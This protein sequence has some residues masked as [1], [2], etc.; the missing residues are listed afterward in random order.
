MAPPKA[1]PSSATESEQEL[2][3]TLLEEAT[4]GLFITG[5][6]MRL[7]AVNPRGC[8][9]TGYS[10]D[11]LRQRTIV[12]LLDPTELARAPLQILESK[13][14]ETLQRERL[15]VRRDGTRVPYEITA[16]RLADGRILGVVRDISE[17]RR[18]MDRLLVGTQAIDSALAGIAFSDLQARITYANASFL[19][20]WGFEHVEEVAG[21][22]AIEFWTT[23]EEPTAVIATILAQGS[24]TGEMTAKR[25]DG[26]TFEAELA[27]TLLRDGDGKAVGLMASFQ[28]ISK[29]KHDERHI[30][31][32]ARLYALLSGVNQSI[33]RATGEREFLQ[34]ICD[35]AVGIGGFRMAWAGL[36]TSATGAIEPVARAGDSNGYLD[37]KF[38][39]SAFQAT[40]QGPTGAA[41]R[42]G[43]IVTTEDI[44]T[45]PRMAPWRDAALERGYRSSAAVPFRH[46]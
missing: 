15:L 23:V 5:P 12:D 45:D 39:T 24:W 34:S 37:L 32:L 41:L 7:D 31:A 11:E 10:L 42:T 35:V 40:G 33:V 36:R 26:S 8:E 43:V 22:S 16:R 18:T 19:R 38:S 44:A 9:I 30:A 28:D 21:R 3:R 25:R 1:A 14:G 4:D 46:P 2:L 29:R 13:E 27:A 17:R 20:L 6:G